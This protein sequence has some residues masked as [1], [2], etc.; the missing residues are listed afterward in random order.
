MADEQPTVTQTVAVPQAG[1]VRERLASALGA[2]YDVRARIG[3][4]GFAEVYE[5]LDRQLERR[6]AVKV[7]CPDLIWAEGSLALLREEARAIAAL[8]HPNILPIHFVGEGQG[9]VYYA[10]PFVEGDPLSAALKREG[11]MSAD[12]HQPG[13]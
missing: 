11:P 12:C 9:L 6:L 8:D 3:S 1:P 10:M 2:E 5:V 7:L 4:G 13:G